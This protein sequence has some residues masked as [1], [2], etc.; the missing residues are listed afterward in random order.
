MADIKLS[1]LAVAILADASEMYL[2]AG[3]SRKATLENL[4]NFLLGAATREAVVAATVVDGTLATAYEDGD[5][6]DGVTLATGDRILLKNQTAAEENGPYTVEAS[7]APTRATDFDVSAEAILGTTFHVIGGT[8]NANTL[9][10]HTTTG[11]ITLGTTALTFARP[12]T[13]KIDVVQAWTAAQYSDFTALTSGTNIS[14]DLD[15]GPNF[16]V[17]LAHTATLDNPSNM[18]VGQTGIIAVTQDGG[19]SKTL[20]YGAFYKFVG[21]VAPVLSTAGGSEDS[22]HYF[23]RSATEIHVS[24]ALDW[25]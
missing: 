20:A 3:G 14:I 2:N 22:L 4:R 9:W 16:D 24:S 18:N 10:M 17:T 12:S 13:A 25:S 1:A 15:T 6:L 19:G 7:G 23:V 21:G 8:V 5:T 11:A